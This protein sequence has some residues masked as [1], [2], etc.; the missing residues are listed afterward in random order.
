MARVKLSSMPNA[1]KEYVVNFPR[2]DGGLNTWELDYRLNAN[3][4]PDMVNLWWKDGVLC[5]RE[6]QVYASGTELGTGWSAYEGLYYD[7]A[8]FHIGSKLYHADLSETEKQENELTLQ[9]LSSGIPENPGTWF[10][11]G[12][13]LYYKNRG[14]YYAISFADDAFSCA[15]VDAY[16]PV[17]LINTEPTTAAGGEYQGENRLCSQKTVWY[18]TV[19]GVKEYHLPVQDIDSVDKVIVDEE[20]LAEGDGYTV[21]FAAGIVTFTTEP[22]HHEPVRVNTVKITFSKENPEAYNS[23]MDCCTAAVYGGDQNVCVVLSGCEA[24]PNA[25]FWCGNHAVMDPGYFPFEQYNLAGDAQ[26]AI[27]GFGKQQSMLVIFKER[28]IGRASFGTQEMASG[29]V[30]LT[31]N[32]TAINST[33][34]C[35]LPG[36]IQTVANNLVFASKRHGVCVVRDSSA[37]YE[38][39][40][41]PMSRKVDNGLLPLLK[42]AETVC[43]HD[44]GERYWLAANG[45]VYCW[46]Y[47]LSGY[48]DP[49][50]FYFTNIN[51][52]AFFTAGDKTLHMD[53][54]GRVTAMHPNFRDYSGPILKRYRFAAQY[55]GSYDRLKDVVSVI[56]TVKGATDTTL[57]V[58]YETDYETRE[59]LTPVR[60]T[61][62]RLYPRNLTYRE[63]SFRKFATVVRRKPG[64]R[65]VRHF[66]MAMENNEIGMDMAVI[67]AQV[68]YRYQG[69]DR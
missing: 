2:L 30:L 25:Y 44:D 24:Q 41:T 68:F 47:T 22:K 28:S 62:W 15:G 18:S 53:G 35:D 54:L 38:N 32:Y 50:W 19:A 26:D 12:D 3:E 40:I 67:S 21:D 13:R 17:I 59:D 27:V 23:I 45:E 1:N 60:S 49:V 63:L 33:I 55:M 14:G 61:S 8:F 37:A 66:T 69:R 43:S 65:H 48:S 6:G 4:S 16:T 20:E 29:R 42:R 5:S 9:E 64:C 39:N 31:M 36:S 46:D 7:H 11:Y 57:H 56:F 52:A 34:G 58:T 51:A 10:R